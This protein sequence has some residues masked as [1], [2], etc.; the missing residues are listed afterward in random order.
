MSG[1]VTV[2]RKIIELKGVVCNSGR[3]GRPSLKNHGLKSLGTR[4]R[5]SSKE[6]LLDLR[7]RRVN[8]LGERVFAD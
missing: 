4:K 8:K 2:R 6:R 1:L 3:G 5:N 7:A